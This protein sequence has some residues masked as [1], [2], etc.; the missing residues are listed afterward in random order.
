MV[1]IEKI[2]LSL[3]V[4]EADL[5]MDLSFVFLSATLDTRWEEG[6]VWPVSVGVR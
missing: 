1:D 6:Y 4:T 5:V 3:F 2:M